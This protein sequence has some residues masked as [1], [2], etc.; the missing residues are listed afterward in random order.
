[1]APAIHMGDRDFPLA[2]QLCCDVHAETPSQNGLPGP[3]IP[4]YHRP[5]TDIVILNP[6]EHRCQI[7]QLVM[8]TNQLGR[9]PVV[10]QRLPRNQNLARPNPVKVVRH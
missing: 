10:G 2:L 6:E 1:M 3:N 9:G 4:R 8:S 5:T 7:G